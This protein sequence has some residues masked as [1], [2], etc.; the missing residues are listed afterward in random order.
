MVQLVIIAN[1]LVVI[2]RLICYVI[3]LHHSSYNDDTLLLVLT[4]SHFI[5]CFV[6]VMYLPS[7]L[8]VTTFLGEL[9]GY[10]IVILSNNVVCMCIVCV[11]V[12]VGVL[13]VQG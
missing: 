10:D 11:H 6:S 5:F 4:G 7:L 12:C 13:V 9:S 1:Q 3:K 2:V 8:R